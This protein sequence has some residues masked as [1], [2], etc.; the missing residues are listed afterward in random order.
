MAVITVSREYGSCGEEIA[1]LVAKELGYSY[2]DKELLAEVAREANTTEEQIRRYDE[3]DEHGTRNFLR[4]LFLPDYPRWVAFPYYPGLD[5]PYA[6]IESEP[7][8]EADEVMAFFR[9][10]VERLWKR[11]NVVIV[12]RGSQKILAAKPDTLHLRFIASLSDRSQKVMGQEGISF[13][14]A[15][16]RVEE[17]DKQRAHHLK[18]HYDADWDDPRLYHLVL[19]TSLMTTEQAVQTIITAVQYQNQ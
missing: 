14:E 10:V 9:H 5:W 7:K 13:A 11:G 6:S 19:N 15:L 3:K 2:F 18:H 16:K 17:V 1:R 4:K 8:L 12:G